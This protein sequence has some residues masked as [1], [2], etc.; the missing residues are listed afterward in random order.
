MFVPR[1]TVVI[2]GGTLLAS[3]SLEAQAVDT[4]AMRAAA[5][6]FLAGC[7]AGTALWGQTLCGPLVI[8]DPESRFAI[9]TQKPASG[10]FWAQDGFYA[11]VLPAGVQVANTALNWNGE[12]WSFVLAPLPADPVVRRGLL[13]HEAFHRVQPMLGLDGRDRLNAHLDERDGRYWLRLELRALAVAVRA[14]DPKRSAALQ[15]AVLF[16]A[17]RQGLYPGADTLEAALEKAEGLAEYTGARMALAGSAG[18][19]VIAAG[20]AGFETRPSYARALGYGTGPMMGVLLDRLRP[21]WRSGVTTDGF[22]A[23]LPAAIGWKLPQDLAKAAAQ[24]ANVYGGV[25]IAKEEDGRVAAREALKSDYRQ[26]LVIGPVLLLPSQKLNM[27]FNPNTVVPLD[28]LGTV[29]PTG[30]FTAQ[31]GAIE[32][33]EGGALITPMYNAVRVPAATSLLAKG[34]VVVGQGW[35]LTMKPGWR[36]APGAR[37]GD[38]TV[39]E[40]P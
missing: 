10:E 2:V 34:T 8:V 15:D 40:G 14:R 38:Y 33:T 24:R 32:V 11:G 1:W 4:A 12:R 5:R 25:A 28:T 17:R 36:L 20:V 29:Y 3:G 31:W 18:D 13:F 27:S 21:D 35:T 19:S 37:A 30:S 39:V 9:A 6:E 26:R 23:Q 16:R 22:A 7:D